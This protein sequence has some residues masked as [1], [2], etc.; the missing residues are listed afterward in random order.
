MMVMEKDRLCHCNIKW[1]LT[2][3]A[4][5]VDSVFGAESTQKVVSETVLK[6]TFP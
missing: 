6:V 5:N 4:V 1:S 3:N 2:L